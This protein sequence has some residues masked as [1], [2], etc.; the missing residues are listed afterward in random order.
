MPQI[1][2]S[3]PDGKKQYEQKD[4]SGSLFINRNKT[5]D[6]SPDM[7]GDVKIDGHI[8][9]IAAWN[10]SSKSGMQYLSLSF[11]E[12]RERTGQSGQVSELKQPE[13]SVS[14][15]LK[16]LSDIKSGEVPF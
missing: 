8:Y 11:S 9:R 6:M 3:N 5:K 2:H 16:E 12:P 14:S 13:S 1:E 7:T 4:M 15:L 10:K